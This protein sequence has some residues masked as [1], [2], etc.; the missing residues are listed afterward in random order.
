MHVT[1][2]IAAIKAQ[3]SF[4]KKEEQEGDEKRTL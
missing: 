3:I 2:K 4:L 1:M